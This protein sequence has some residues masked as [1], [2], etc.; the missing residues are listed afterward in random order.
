MS[1]QITTSSDYKD[2]IINLKQ[3]IIESRNNVLKIVNK[4]LVF[5]YFKL[6]KII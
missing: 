2:L 6:G 3:E 5:L 4:E 1:K